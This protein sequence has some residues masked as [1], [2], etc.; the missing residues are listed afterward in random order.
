LINTSAPTQS[1]DY[2]VAYDGGAS[3]APTTTPTMIKNVSSLATTTYH[4][5][6]ILV[7]VTP[8]PAAIAGDYED[9]LT[10]SIVAN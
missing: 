1:T 2:Q 4:V 3:T 9:T 6:P 8:Y 7:D 10:L 5:S